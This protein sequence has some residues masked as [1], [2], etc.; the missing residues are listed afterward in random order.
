MSCIFNICKQA[1]VFTVLL[2]LKPATAP[3]QDYQFMPESV[4][5]TSNTLRAIVWMEPLTDYGKA[6]M[7]LGRD[8]LS[9]VVIDMTHH[10]GGPLHHHHRW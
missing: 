2:P 7:N 5:A 1:P 4:A 9:I 3:T 6:H 8:D 10:A